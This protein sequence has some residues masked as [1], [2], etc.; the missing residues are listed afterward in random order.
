MA[1]R[2]TSFIASKAVT[3]AASPGWRAAAVEAS[4]YVFLVWAAV[5]AFNV[6]A[7]SDP[8]AR[9]AA[10]ANLQHIPQLL[11]HLPRNSGH[12]LV[13][14]L[15]ILAAIGPGD[16]LLRAFR[17]PARD[18]FDRIAFGTA[19]GFAVLIAVAYLL[20]AAQLLRV[21]AEVPLL[22]AGVVF[23][24]VRIRRWVLE[25]PLVQDAVRI[26]RPLTIALIV[27]LAAA[28][29]VNLLGA[30]HPE[31][32][33][34]AR[35][36][37]L[38]QAERYAQHGGFYNILAAERIWPYAL[39]HY[40]ETL[41]A[42]GWVLTGHIGAKLLAWG[43]AVAI[44][45][46]TVAFARTWFSSTAAGVLA[47]MIF[48]TT[49]VLAWST[50][51]GNNDLA[52]VPFVLLAMH[53]LLVWRNGGSALPLYGAGLL[54]GM[55]Y[56]IKPFGAFTLIAIAIVAA[57]ILISRRTPRPVVA[58]V[59]AG[60]A[61]F[62][63]L[64]LLPA[65]IT[66]TW[67]IGDPFYPLFASLFPSRYG[68]TAMSQHMGSEIV[69][70]FI[71]H[72]TPANVLSLPWSMTTDV[73]R[74]RDLMGPVWLATLP[75]W[76]AM[77]FFVRRDAAIIR[78]LFAFVAVST[79]IVFLSGAEEFRYIATSVAIVALFIGYTVFCLD[80]SRAR[81]LQAVLVATLMA[82]GILG[83]PLVTPLL[84]GAAVSSVMGAEYINW[85]Y[86]YEGQPESAIQLQW[87]PILQ[88]TNA[89]L[90]PRHDKIY[91]A[92]TI[93]LM[94]VYS[95]VELFNGTFYQGPAALHEWS[96][97]SPD[98]YEHLRA[99]GCTYVLL[100]KPDVPALKGTR[101]W[102][103]L[104]FV[105]EQPGLGGPTVPDELYKVVG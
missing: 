89:H 54:A 94:N 81:P 24:A 47:A 32:G 4:G 20:A 96:L 5:V 6:F 45:L 82:F 38:S 65:L 88:Y 75:V 34:D 52:A 100:S 14:I 17:I 18:A 59:L 68:A 90:D 55:T 50:T 37:H 78:P 102:N 28:M 83:N 77:P 23:S 9:A 49:P 69:R 63:V 19:A 84:R 41:Y 85:P 13:L 74:Y 70:R 21:E 26:P 16:A 79:A 99:E 33:F 64:G 92:A 8:A 43:S 103:H 73:V 53:G 72:V 86:L 1:D 29:Y 95:E 62:A 98:A 15:T 48:F 57:G 35:W 80:W 67:M 76:I 93:Q 51:T 7:F 71:E 12:V 2:E 61:G 44:V 104:K 66:A 27:V 36:Y 42:F 22:L 101:V 10:V 60:Y 56:G 97:A 87:V 40:Q 11:T 105:V 3:V 58:R 46:A 91:D 39:P 30:V 31:V 25:M